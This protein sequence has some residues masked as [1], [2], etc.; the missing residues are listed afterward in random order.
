LLIHT[1]APIL[2]RLILIG[3]VVCIIIM[4]TLMGSKY[5]AFLVVLLFLGGIIVVFVYISALFTGRPHVR[6][7]GY[8][9][10]AIITQI[11]VRSIFFS[12]AVYWTN[13]L[14]RFSLPLLYSSFHLRV[15]ILC[16]SYL[17]VCLIIRVKVSRK[18]SGAL[19]GRAVTVS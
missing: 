12:N 6:S 16:L 8:R 7:T 13:D 14:N 10:L 4:A 3:A 17:L 1:T 2:A 9:G 19:K 5:V 11:T 15:V 18:H